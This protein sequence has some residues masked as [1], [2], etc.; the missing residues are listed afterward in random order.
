MGNTFFT[1]TATSNFQKIEFRQNGIE[2][3]DEIPTNENNWAF[4]DMQNLYKGVQERGWK[5]QWDRFRQYLWKNHNV[6]NAVIFMGYI[7]GNKNLYRHLERVGFNLQFRKVDRLENGEIR[8][9]NIDVDLVTYALYNINEYRKAIIVADDGDY[10]K[11]VA[12]LIGL[13][14]LKLIISS[15]P[16][17]NTSHILKEIALKSII[18]IDSLRHIIEL[19]F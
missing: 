4:L 13:D 7:K 16:I 11:T 19:R 15:H 10:F 12:C 3:N 17:R 5:I 6:T 8:K 1:S 9:G 2:L 18:S 14:K